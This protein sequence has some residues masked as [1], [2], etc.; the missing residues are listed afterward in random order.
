MKSIASVAGRRV[1]VELTGLAGRTRDLR[2]DHHPFELRGQNLDS[3][4]HGR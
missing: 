4:K 2:I 3:I 1:Y